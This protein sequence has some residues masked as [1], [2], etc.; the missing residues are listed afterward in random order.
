MKLKL[1]FH[2]IIQI[3]YVTIQNRGAQVST[4]NKR[5][6]VLFFSNLDITQ[7]A[8]VQSKVAHRSPGIHD[9][10]PLAK[11]YFSFLY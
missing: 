3:A 6:I 1:T 5:P 4:H 11:C 8:Q 9:G 2:K 10:L 7:N